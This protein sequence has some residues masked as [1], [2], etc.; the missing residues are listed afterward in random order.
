MTLSAVIDVAIGLALLYLLLGLIASALLAW[1]RGA[2]GR[3]AMRGGVSEESEL[4]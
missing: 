3:M 2:G 4:M 1:R